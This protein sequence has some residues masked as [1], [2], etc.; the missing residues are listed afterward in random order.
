MPGKQRHEQVLPAL[1][2]VFIVHARR[3]RP[4]ELYKVVEL[5]LPQEFIASLGNPDL[6]HKS[7]RHKTVNA[8]G[9]V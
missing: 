1:T 4:A 5:A 3:H 8:S 2:S 6:L 9:G 7:A